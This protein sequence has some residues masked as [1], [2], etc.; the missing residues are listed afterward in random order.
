MQLTKYTQKYAQWRKEVNEI[1]KRTNNNNR[2]PTINGVL[3][4]EQEFMF[5]SS[6]T[7][8]LNALV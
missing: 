7:L 5:N 8:S 2:E 3:R 6:A 4:V 1:E